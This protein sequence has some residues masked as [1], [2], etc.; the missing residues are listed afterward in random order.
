MFHSTKQQNRLSVELRPFRLGKSNSFVSF[1][2]FFFLRMTTIY[3]KQEFKWLVIGSAALALQA[4]FIN[5]VTF[6]GNF[7]I[8]NQS[9]SE[10]NNKEKNPNYHLFFYQ[11]LLMSLE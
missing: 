3:D 2:F 10:M 9:I 11:V 4:G 6:S 1:H 5:A 7:P 8:G